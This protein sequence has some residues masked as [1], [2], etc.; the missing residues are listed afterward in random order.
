MNSVAKKKNIDFEPRYFTID[1]V[2]RADNREVSGNLRSCLA[3]VKLLE[4]MK[5]FVINDESIEIKEHYAVLACDPILNKSVIPSL[6][7]SAFKK[8]GEEWKFYKVYEGEFP[9]DEQ[10]RKT[11]G[12]LIPGSVYAAYDESP[13]WY[14][15]LLQCIQKIHN[16]HKHINLLCICFRSQIVAQALGGRVAKMESGFYRGGESL[17]V[18]PSLYELNYVKKLNLEVKDKLVITQVHGDY[19]VNVPSEAVVHASSERANVEIFSIGENVLAL[20]GHPEY[21]EAWSVGTNYLINK[22]VTDD[23]DS[24]AAEYIQQRFPGVVNQDEL[25]RICFSFLKKREGL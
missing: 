15:D 9:S 1:E 2:L 23:Y 21:N 3:D 22:V 13:T 12:I 17:Q 5:R 24:Y 4:Y 20:Q 25:L 18:K 19:I 14:K 8:H 11:T 10:L 16:D 6:F 7:Y